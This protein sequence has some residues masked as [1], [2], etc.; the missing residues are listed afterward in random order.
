MGIERL[1]RLVL[2]EKTLL[3]VDEDFPYWQPLCR[4]KTGYGPS[5][6]RWSIAREVNLENGAVREVVTDNTG[7]ETVIRAIFFPD[8]TDKFRWKALGAPG[9]PLNE[10]SWEQYKKWK[11]EIT[12][13]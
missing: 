6:H 13:L 10:M 5:R 12:G 11:R 4:P 1:G 7:S 9:Q 3:P 8:G 2:V